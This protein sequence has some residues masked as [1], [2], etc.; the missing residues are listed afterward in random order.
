VRASVGSPQ[1]SDS[2]VMRIMVRFLVGGPD[3]GLESR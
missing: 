2:S 3:R 1:G